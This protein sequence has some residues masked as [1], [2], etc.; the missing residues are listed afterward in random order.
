MNTKKNSAIPIKIVDIV[1]SFLAFSAST[2]V[3]QE[4]LLNL[5]IDT[6]LKIIES[7]NRINI[8]DVKTVRTNLL[9]FNK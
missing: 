2:S 5:L 4:M 3:L 6:P 7:A 8:M 9:I 1:I